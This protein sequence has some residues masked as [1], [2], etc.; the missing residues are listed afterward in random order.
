ANLDGGSSATMYLGGSVINRPS[1]KL[2]E[3]TVPTAFIVVPSNNVNSPPL[4]R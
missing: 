4:L 3:R 2:G 1:D